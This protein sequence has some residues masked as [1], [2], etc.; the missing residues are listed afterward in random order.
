MNAEGSLKFVQFR[1]RDLGNAGFGVLGKGIYWTRCC[2]N[3]D[4]LAPKITMG[5]CKLKI[6]II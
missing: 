4:L 3:T 1:V 2:V 5:E 6:V